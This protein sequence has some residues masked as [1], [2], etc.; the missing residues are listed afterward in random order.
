MPADQGHVRALTHVSYNLCAALQWRAAMPPGNRLWENL[1]RPP[2]SPYQDQS[3]MFKRWYQSNNVLQSSPLQF[4]QLIQIFL[5]LESLHK[6]GL[7]IYTLYSKLTVSKEGWV[8][9]K[10]GLLKMGLCAV[11]FP[12]AFNSSRKGLQCNSLAV[13]IAIQLSIGEVVSLCSLQKWVS[14]YGTF[15]WNRQGDSHTHSACVCFGLQELRQSGIWVTFEVFEFEF[16]CNCNYI[17]LILSAQLQRDNCSRDEPASINVQN[18]SSGE[19]H[20]QF[21]ICLYLNLRHGIHSS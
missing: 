20:P 7:Y 6:P 15:E 2:P 21:W 18:W 10:N 13:W 9:E 19:F 16:S 14:I 11:D 1:A 3:G 5:L 17:Y 12:T 8:L 4:H